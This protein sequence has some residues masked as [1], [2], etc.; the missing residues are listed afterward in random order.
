MNGLSSPPEDSQ[1]GD[2]NDL[3]RFCL[4]PHPLTA[5]SRHSALDRKSVV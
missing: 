4:T 2:K 3:S 5:I 1:M